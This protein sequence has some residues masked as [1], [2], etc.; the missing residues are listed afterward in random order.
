MSNLR[1][2]F[3]RT[4]APHFHSANLTLALHRRCPPK[5]FLHETLR[6]RT[7]Q[8]RF[9]AYLSIVRKE[10]GKGV[11]YCC[12][13]NDTLSEVQLPRFRT[14]Q[15]IRSYYHLYHTVCCLA[16]FTQPRVPTE[17]FH[18]ITRSRSTFFAE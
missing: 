16:T 5:M 6:L 10:G 15:T 1:D 13:S 12:E 18:L 4:C 17:I 14:A 8:L 9:I 11:F 2:C 7:P 3:Q